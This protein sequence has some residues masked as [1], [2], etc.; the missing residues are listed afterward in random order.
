MTTLKLIAFYL[1]ILFV[2]VPNVF[3]Q[4]GKDSYS[5]EF[6]IGENI[7]FIYRSGII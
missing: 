3:S 1:C 4:S 6:D 5:K 2:S 7:P